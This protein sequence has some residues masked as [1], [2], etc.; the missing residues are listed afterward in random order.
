MLQVIG[1]FNVGQKQTYKGVP[2]PR[3]QVRKAVKVKRRVHSEMASSACLP[4]QQRTT[5]WHKKKR[6]ALRIGRQLI[7]HGGRLQMGWVDWSPTGRES[8]T[9]PSHFR[10]LAKCCRSKHDFGHPRS[11][12]RARAQVRKVSDR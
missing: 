4:A 7:T 6:V 5:G 2:A 10:K 3:V 12:V 9:N 11:S 1:G 8:R